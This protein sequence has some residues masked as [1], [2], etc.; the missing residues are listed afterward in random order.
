M[1]P[2]QKWT[3]FK[4]ACYILYR[5]I[6]KHLPD[7]PRPIGRVSFHIRRAV[8]RPLL[9]E[10]DG[11]FGI[12]QG[13]DFGNGRCLVMRN[14]G[15]LGR[16]TLIS[17]NGI[18]TVGRHVMMGSQCIII[19]QNHRYL[20][21]GYD[22][23]DVK[24]VLIDDYAW[25]GHRATILAG[26]RVGRH[27]IVGAGAVVTRDVPDYGIAVGNPA[28]VVKYRKDVGVTRGTA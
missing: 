4:I 5:M 16:S 17:G 21:E 15:N 9:R 26:V 19:T 28:R 18:V 13:T 8:C 7:D 23:Y 1:I 3:P 2:K 10:T 20:E 25:I 24:D 6:A 11:V 14:H 22:G 27:A 12:G